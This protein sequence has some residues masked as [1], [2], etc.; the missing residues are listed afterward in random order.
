METRVLI[1]GGAGFV[2]INLVQ[3]LPRGTEDRVLVV[4]KVTYAANEVEICKL[5]DGD[6]L[7]FERLDLCDSQALSECIDTFRPE[8]V[9]HL[10]AETVD[11]SIDDPRPFLQANIVGTFELLEAV[12]RF[13]LTLSSE[14]R[15]RFRFLHV[16][17]DEVYGA[18][19]TESPAVSE[20]SAYHPRSPYAAT[21]AASDHLV[22]SWYS[23]YGLPDTGVDLRKTLGNV[24]I[25][26]SKEQIRLGWEMFFVPYR[27]QVLGNNDDGLLCIP[28]QVM[29]TWSHR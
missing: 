8:A 10:A 16:S 21:K 22:H 23:T 24:Q 2:G 4:D 20:G 15:D 13:W 26:L 3:S 12:R 29:P 14:Q 28:L 25:E 19:S 11:R 5:S 18:L 27:S 7:R 9:V 6:R 17:T 1:T